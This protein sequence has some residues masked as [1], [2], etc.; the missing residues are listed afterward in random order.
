MPSTS[1]T[2]E[3]SFSALRRLK[4]NCELRWAAETEQLADTAL[5]P[6]QSRQAEPEGHFPGICL[7]ISDQHSNFL[8]IMRNRP[9]LHSQLY[10]YFAVSN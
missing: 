5:P 7:C 9:E 6:E 10:S 4:T 8:E 1:A 2:A 3:R